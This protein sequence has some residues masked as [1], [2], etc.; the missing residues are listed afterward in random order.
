MQAPRPAYVVDG[1]TIALK[2][3]KKSGEVLFTRPE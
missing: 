2:T 1:M 3:D